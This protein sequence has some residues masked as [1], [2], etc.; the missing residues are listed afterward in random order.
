M[1]IPRLA[2]FLTVLS[3]TLAAFADEGWETIFDGKSL[4]GW[5][6]SE[7]PDSI[8]VVDGMIYCDGPRAHLFYLGA[9]G[10]AGFENF[11][12]E[13]EVKAMPGANSGVYF[14]ATWQDEGWPRLSGTE[15]QVN[16][17]QPAFE[18][19]YIENK[20]TGSLYGYR[21]LYKAM[22]RDEEWF[23]L[24][25]RVTKPRAQVRINGKLMIDYVEPSNVPVLV[26][27][28]T[29][30]MLTKG[31]FALQCHDEKSQVCYRNIRV[32]RLPSGEDAA[33][34]KPVYNAQDLQRQVLARDNFP[35]VNLRTHLSDALTFDR[36]QELRNRTGIFAGIVYH[37]GSVTSVH[38]DA[39]A[40]AVVN[41]FKDEPAF[42]GLE[43]TGDDLMTLSP[44][45]RAKF[46]YIVASRTGVLVTGNFNNVIPQATEKSPMDTYVDD[47][48][49]M[50]E[51]QPIDVFANIMVLPQGLHSA[52]EVL[53]TEERM[54]KVIAAAARHGV[55]FEINPRLR[56]PSEDFIKLAKGAKVRFTI[57]SDSTSADDYADWPYLLEVQQKLKLVWRDMY[58]PGHD[59][60]RAQRDL[61]K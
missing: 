14:H 27:G 45:A 60:T 51:T 44:Q 13:L 21:N 48:V 35:H 29:R 19:N 5:K 20:K 47:V 54:Q 61:K 56:T 2:L 33:V 57:G 16:N 37:A 53:W 11:E 15:V 7:H 46:D 12:L 49:R 23:T 1:K 18:K 42:V 6:T 34:T 38:D 55:A 25:I 52:P 9:D 30:D 22:A 58:V 26:A 31:T 39:T 36:V 3:S 28:A 32:R 10:K 8:K 59:P 41:E 4:A 43:V 17:D 24:N 50:I 40:Q